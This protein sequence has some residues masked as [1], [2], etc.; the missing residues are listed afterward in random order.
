MA[1][2]VTRVR[3]A[4]SFDPH[5][6]EDV[7]P[8]AGAAPDLLLTEAGLDPRARRTR[9]RVCP[10]RLEAAVDCAHRFSSCWTPSAGVALVDGRG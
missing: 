1:D 5:E 8:I 10:H 3:N 2:T 7:S 4:R 9:D 6:A